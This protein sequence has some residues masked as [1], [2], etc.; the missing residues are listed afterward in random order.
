MANRVEIDVQVDPTGR[1][2]ARINLLENR[3]DS[4]GSKS[5]QAGQAGRDALDGFA[6]G[7]GIPT[8]IAAA[9]SALGAGIILLG[10]AAKNASLE[11]A[12]AQRIL[13]SDAQEAKL[14]FSAVQA[15]ARKF[16][17]DLA[18]SNT[19]AEQSFSRFLRVVK[20][21]GLTEN[22][23]SYRKKFADLA[24]AYG[25]QAT[26]VE[27]LTSQL[28]SGQDEALN[29]LGIADPSQL[30]KRYA[31][32]VNKT[33][34]NLTEEE[35]VRARLLAVIEKGERFEGAAAQRLSEQTG[36]WALLSKSIADATTNL[37]D[38]LTKQTVVGDI[39]GV[40]TALIA[41]KNPFTAYQ[42][43]LDNQAK[44][45]QAAAAAKA[46][47]DSDKYFTDQTNRLGTPGALAD[48]F[49]SFRNRI[50]LLGPE[51]A[52]KERDNFIQQYTAIFKDKRLS[53]STALFAEDQY[54]QIRGIFSPEKRQEIEGEF[55][56][57]WNTYAKTA[58]GAL[59]TA[60][61]AAEANFK[62][63]ADRSTGGNNP[64]VKIL[65]DADERA[66]ELE[67]TFR[68]L[69]S[70]VVK[71]LQKAEDAYT[72]QKLM[73]LQLDQ[74]L[75]AASLRREA[76][77][78]EQFS[79]ITGGEQR[80]LN[81]IDAQISA[82]ENIP[83]LLAKA[84][85]ISRGLVRLQEG[86]FNEFGER[87]G[88]GPLQSELAI[89]QNR[90]NKEIFDELT[91]IRTSDL[92][93]EAGGRA[94][95][96]VNQALINLFESF[97]PDEQARIARGERGASTQREF[98]DAF[99]GRAESFREAIRQEV[100]KAAVADKAIAAVREDISR[101]EEARRSGLDSREADARLLSTTGELSP[102]EM[103]ADIR[104]A[105]IEA[106]RREADRQVKAQE[107]ANKALTDATT[108]TNKLVESIDKLAGDVRDPNNR[109]L[110]LE[111]RNRA[112]ADVRTELY[113]DLKGAGGTF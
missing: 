29:R 4:L 59:K 22:L 49:G 82:A 14:E 92:G 50:T 25:L 91:R 76:D 89:D 70:S 5:R 21:A 113:G 77:R 34:E 102:G 86:Q 66:K 104:Q 23:E 110:L 65:V 100:E 105:R 68:V 111:V 63:L 15:E 17:E 93:G 8:S 36:Q 80:R 32:Q 46:L 26:E 64:F 20:A 71:E 75:K 37:G 53:T 31:E 107:D 73:A 24:A 33:V 45:A 90:I 94:R 109:R 62:V 35:K 52:A 7:L 3:V 103:S 19:Q 87:T 2:I 16:G 101:I 48:P 79:G 47:A 30:Y 40:V 12:T 55:T 81:Q 1:G 96:A 57:F 97:S 44:A 74:E 39:P 88:S 27:T 60:R 51:Q 41:G 10:N 13:K 9:S 106:L 61:D 42:E 85:A 78:L 43:R 108:A 38:F 95:D 83:S 98:A 84:E 56:K 6:G 54:K 67:K 112:T 58:L 69:G 99:Q 18:L 11:A 72:K 28:L